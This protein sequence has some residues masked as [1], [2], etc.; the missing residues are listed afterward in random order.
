MAE[1]VP[2]KRAA[3]M[4]AALIMFTQRGF[5]GTPT[6]M[7]SKSAGVS[8]GILFRYFETKNDLIN[9]VY[10]SAKERMGQATYAGCEQEKSVRNKIRR[11]WGNAIRWGAE[12]PY[13]F[14]FV[15]QFSSSPF[16]TD[17]TREEALKNFSLLFEVLNE[18]ISTGTLKNQDR[19]L[20]LEMLYSANVAVVKKLIQSGDPKDIDETIDKSF[21]IVWS[22]IARK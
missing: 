5:H 11:I 20:A 2:D 12:N 21:D 17:V 7:I 13:E 14:L 22:G 16:I 4:K 1:D 19:G 18:G 9:S 8:T 15:E 6:S 10:F 3:I